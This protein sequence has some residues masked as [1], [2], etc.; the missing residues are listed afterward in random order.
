MTEYKV[1]FF[2]KFSKRVWAANL[3]DAVNKG[4]ALLKNGGIDFIKAKRVTKRIEELKFSVQQVGGSELFAF[5]FKEN[6]QIE[7]K[8]S[9][10]LQKGC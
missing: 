7:C 10:H 9:V 5:L 3:N 4:T 2:G 1:T 6:G 8:G